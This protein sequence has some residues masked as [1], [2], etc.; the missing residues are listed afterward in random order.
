MRC[1]SVAA[2]VM[3][4]LVS[5]ATAG[6]NNERLM[7]NIQEVY[8]KLDQLTVDGKVL[9]PTRF[10]SGW[11]SGAELFYRQENNLTADEIKL[12]TYLK[13]RSNFD[14]KMLL[15]GQA[16]SW[17]KGHIEGIYGLSV[18]LFPEKD[19]T[20]TDVRVYATRDWRLVKIPDGLKDKWID[21]FYSLIH[22]RMDRTKVDL[23]YYETLTRRDIIQEAA[24]IGLKADLNDIDKRIVYYAKVDTEILKWLKDK[25]AK[26]AGPSFDDIE[27]AAPVVENN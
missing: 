5:V 15:N 16:E 26:L 23:V 21:V 4:L 24:V 9:K 6:D 14:Q 17:P 1:L 25:P 13:R 3:F 27:M 20:P 11:V 12:E 2:C 22:K 18:G 19:G 8:P 10:N 7:L